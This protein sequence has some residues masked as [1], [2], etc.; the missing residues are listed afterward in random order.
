[1]T[2]LMGS[3]DPLCQ[4]LQPESGH[5]I[6]VPLTGANLTGVS[7]TGVSLTGV[8]LIDVYLLYACLSYSPVDGHLP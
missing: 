8:S 3:T 1:M 5:F 6:G 7:L 4:T 2:A